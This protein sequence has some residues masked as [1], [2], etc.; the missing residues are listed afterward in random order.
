MILSLELMNIAVITCIMLVSALTF[1]I[2]FCNLDFL[3]YGER[4]AVNKIIL[5]H[6]QHGHKHLS[7]FGICHGPWHFKTALQTRQIEMS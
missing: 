5:L 7:R 6:N 2:Y 3:P 4:E 1:L